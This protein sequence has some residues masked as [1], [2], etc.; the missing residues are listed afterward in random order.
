MA[1]THEYVMRNGK[2]VVVRTPRGS[3]EDACQFKE[4]LI[5]TA[6][7]AVAKAAVRRLVGRR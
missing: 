6:A 2:P 3:V 5:G 4:N 7:G 1:R